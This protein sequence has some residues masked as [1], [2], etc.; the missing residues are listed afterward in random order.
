[1]YMMNLFV[2]ASGIMAF[3]IISSRLLRNK[4]IT[5]K[6]YAW[7]VSGMFSGVFM[8]I[9]F[10]A[11]G[12]NTGSFIIGAILT[13]LNLSIGFFAFQSLHRKYWLEHE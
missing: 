7:I 2:A 4:R 13:I 6:K 5:S 9:L 1:M 3:V 12:I 10:V 11:I 8:V